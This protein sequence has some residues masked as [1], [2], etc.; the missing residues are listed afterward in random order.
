MLGR[1]IAIRF[2]PEANVL[3]LLDRHLLR[4]VARF[5]K[6]PTNEYCTRDPLTEIDIPCAMTSLTAAVQD[7]HSSTPRKS[8]QQI[9]NVMP[10]SKKLGSAVLVLALGS[11]DLRLAV[12]PKSSV[13]HPSAYLYVP[14]Q[15]RVSPTKPA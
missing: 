3:Q 10:L 14:K 13:S 2:L 1:S 6:P 4:V 5:K 8:M 7:P 9:S 12:I 11:L 15:V